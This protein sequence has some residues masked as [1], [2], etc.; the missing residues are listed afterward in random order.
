MDTVLLQKEVDKSVLYQ[1]MSIP[2]VYQQLFMDKLGIPLSHGQSCPIKLLIDGERYDAQI[3]NQDFD[4]DKFAG[5][6]DILQIRYS[7]QSPIAK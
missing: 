4:Q 7:E 5:H 1:G 6:T 2:K 3:K